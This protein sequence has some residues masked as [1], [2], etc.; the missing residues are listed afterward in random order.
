MFAPTTGLPSGDWITPTIDG[1]APFWSKPPLAFWTTALSIRL[2]GPSEFA[3]RLPMLLTVAATAGLTIDL[4]RVGRDRA[5]G[6]LGGCIFASMVLPLSMA[7][8]VLTDQMLTLGTTL[9]MVAFW[10][11]MTERN[12]LAGYLFFVGLAIAT[13]PP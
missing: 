8:F 1:V 3:A 10:R 7:G 13:Q 5:F 9:A 12:R 11:A 4:G 2:F 6:L